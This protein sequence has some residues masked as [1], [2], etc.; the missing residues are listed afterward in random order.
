M[1]DH[2]A[3]FKTHSLFQMSYDKKLAVMK[4]N[5]YFQQ[6]R[7]NEEEKP[8]YEIITHTVD[9]A[10]SFTAI[11][12]FGSKVTKGTAPSKNEAKR[13][14]ACHMLD[15]LCII[16]PSKFSKKTVTQ[17]EPT[18]ERIAED[19]NK[20][21][22]SVNFGNLLETREKVLSVFSREFVKNVAD[23]LI[24]H[25]ENIDAGFKQ[26]TSPKSP[27]LDKI[28][29]RGFDVVNT[30]N[31]HRLFKKI[32][33]EMDLK[34]F[35]EFLETAKNDRYIVMI[36]LNFNL[37]AVCGIGDTPE[38]AIGNCCKNAIEYFLTFNS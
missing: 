34:Y 16:D 13:I 28:K 32:V 8:T 2:E 35:S 17:V 24:D 21:R 27:T 7:T 30:E 19:F 4:L 3:V 5:T 29:I 18:R 33:Q 15:H 25:F 20:E 1:Y 10:P 31:A 12:T 38:E 23:N 6:N 36:K 14:A 22:L 9:K 37:F 26:A 11:C